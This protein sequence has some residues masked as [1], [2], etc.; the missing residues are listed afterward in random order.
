V[1]ASVTLRSK[2]EDRG[3]R[4]L[5]HDQGGITGFS[6]VF[7]Q[8]NV[9]A[10]VFVADTIVIGMMDETA[11]RITQAYFV[12]GT[13]HPHGPCSDELL[14]HLPRVPTLQVDPVAYSETVRDLMALAP[15]GKA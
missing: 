4:R 10:V 5:M 13:N 12:A 14:E 7:P 11:N 6:K 15:S 1:I 3:W 2:L 9:T 8:A